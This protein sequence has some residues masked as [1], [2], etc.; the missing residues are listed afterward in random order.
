MEIL[1]LKIP[2]LPPPMATDGEIFFLFRISRLRIQGTSHG[3]FKSDSK[4][5]F[6]EVRWVSYVTVVYLL[7]KKWRERPIPNRYKV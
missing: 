4:L 1:A 2:S 6:A 7:I 3:D 5:R